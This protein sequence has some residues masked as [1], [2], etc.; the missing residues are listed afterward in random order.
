MNAGSL[1]QLDL[2]FTALADPNRRAVLER[3]ARSGEGSASTLAHGMPISRQAVLK[4]LVVLDRAALVGSRKLGREVLY[5]ARPDELLRTA[6][7][8]EQIATSWDDK[9]AALKEVAEQK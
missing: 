5:S 6:S 4:H 9:L 8:L 7:A 3:L 2:V 1:Q